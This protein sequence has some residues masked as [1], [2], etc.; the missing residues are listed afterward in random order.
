ML[1]LQGQLRLFNHVLKVVAT[2][3]PYSQY[4][5]NLKATELQNMDFQQTIEELN[6]QLKRKVS[7]LVQQE[8]PRTILLL[9]YLRNWKEISFLMLRKQRMVILGS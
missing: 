6:I 9:L 4:K 2:V 8:G 5:T 1:S 3:F 7:K